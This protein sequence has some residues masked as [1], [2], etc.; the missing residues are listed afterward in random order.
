[1]MKHEQTYYSNSEKAVSTL[2]QEGATD[3]K[4]IPVWNFPDWSSEFTRARV[5]M[6]PLHLNFVLFWLHN[7]FFLTSF[8][9]KFPRKLVRAGVGELL[10]TA[11]DCLCM[12][13]VDVL[14]CV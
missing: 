12:G 7:F 6:Q 13:G 14:Y 9:P 2:V 10:F 11:H 1:M 5:E 8:R 3:V 4:L